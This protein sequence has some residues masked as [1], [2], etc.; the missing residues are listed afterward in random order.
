MSRN[1]VK[2][3]NPVFT[4]EKKSKVVGQPLHYILNL[5]FQATLYRRKLYKISISDLI[6]SSF[7]KPDDGMPFPLK[8]II[9]SSSPFGLLGRGQRVK[10]D[11]TDNQ[12]GSLLA[13][14][15]SHRQN[16]SKNDPGKTHWNYWTPTFGSL[17]NSF[18]KQPNPSRSEPNCSLPCSIADTRA[19]ILC[20]VVGDQ[21]EAGRLLFYDTNKWVH[22]NCLLWNSSIQ[23]LKV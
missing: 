20:G 12:L 16:C 9:H 19:C 21:T 11:G 17:K 2:S 18:P 13:K 8:P 4:A 15:T 1:N 23:E 7:T 6:E 14:N 3:S 5:L 10:K 22:L